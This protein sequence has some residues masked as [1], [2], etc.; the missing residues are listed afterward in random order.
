MGI[1]VKDGV[2]GNKSQGNWDFVVVLEFSSME[3]NVQLLITEHKEKK[4]LRYKTISRFDNFYSI[5]KW[6][7]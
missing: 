4:N 3:R 6:D 1:N 2:V 5:Y 7:I